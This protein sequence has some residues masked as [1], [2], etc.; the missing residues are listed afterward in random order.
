MHEI[1]IIQGLSNFG[2]PAKHTFL[3]L[4]FQVTWNREE[5]AEGPRK[6][7]EKKGLE[8]SKNIR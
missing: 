8:N 1:Q 4:T 7:T 6:M 2:K 3:I 5:L